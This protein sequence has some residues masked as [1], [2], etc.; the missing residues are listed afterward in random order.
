MGVI[1]DHVQSRT[2]NLA[3]ANSNAQT[4]APPRRP[5]GNWVARVYR[6][7]LSTAARLL[8]LLL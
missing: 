3:I 1:S 7:F 6:C 8:L 4:V 2:Q 5:H